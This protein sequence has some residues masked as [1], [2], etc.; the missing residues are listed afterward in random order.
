M[1]L[2]WNNSISMEAI[3][4]DESGKDEGKGFMGKIY[5][6]GRGRSESKDEGSLLGGIGIGGIFGKD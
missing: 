3:F 2:L 5:S 1:I 4:G 6:A